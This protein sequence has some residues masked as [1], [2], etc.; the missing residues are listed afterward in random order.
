MS[1]SIT[2]NNNSSSNNNNN[3]DAVSP[4]LANNLRR[5][6]FQ[7][8]P[9][10]KLKMSD[11]DS[12]LASPDIQV[13]RKAVNRIEDSDSDAGTPVK[14]FDAKSNGD[15]NDKDE[16]LAYLINLYPNRDTDDLQEVLITVDWDLDKAKA[17][18]STTKKRKKTSSKSNKKKRR[19]GR[20]MDEEDGEPDSDEKTYKSKVFDSDDDS[21]VEVSNDLTGDKKAVFDFMQTAILAELLMMHQCSQKK[22]EAIIT[23]RP[24]ED[25]R[26]MVDKFQHNKYLD[27]ELLNSAQVLLA[28]RNVVEVLMK[29]CLRLSAN[30]EKAVAAGASMIK[31]QPKGLSPELKLT[32]YQMVGINW[33]AVL[34]SQNVNGILA[35]EMGLGKTIQVI[36]FLTYLKEANLVGENDGPHLIIVPSS[37][38]NNWINEFERWSPG[39]NIVQYYGNPDERK[40]IRMGW[41][42]GE[43]DDVDVIITTYNLTSSTPEERRLFRV[44]P[45]TYVVVD[46]AHMLKNMSTIRYENLVRINAKHRILLTGTPLQNNLLELMSLLMFV[47]PSLFAGKQNDL[48]SLFSKNPKIA[49]AAKDQPFFER[50]QVKNAKQIMRPFVLRRLKSQVLKDLPLKTDEVIKCSLTEKQ[51][52]MYK[53]LMSEFSEEAGSGVPF[54]GPG[55]MMQLRKLANHPLLHRNFYDE[56]KLR[57]MAKK[58]AKDSTYKETNPD[59]VFDDLYWM[60]D[61]AI[62]GLTRFHRCLAGYGLPQEMVLQ[63]AKLE[64]LDE[65][66]PV[67]K[68]D[69]HRVL[70]FSQFTMLLD[71][72]EEYLT[73]R[74]HKFLRLDGQT[75]VPDR[76]ALIDEFT[77][78]SSIFVFLLSTRAGGLGINLTAADTVIIHDIDFNPYN[79]KQAEDR[80]HRM[81]QKNPVRIIRLLAENTIEEGMYEIAQEKLHLEAQV[82][83]NEENE[84]TDRKSVLRLLK[85]TLGQDIHNKSLSLSPTKASNKS[86]DD[87]KVEEF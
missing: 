8:K 27:T 78:D 49:A 10:D 52:E 54:N 6:R 32:S 80:S 17:R 60:S 74:C 53:E 44:L 5:F 45:I 63:S 84:N 71:I 24:F 50:E 69:G 19:K 82:T 67:M 26:D 35:D 12:N 57:P 41:R 11:E 28:T 55:M 23:A 59:H 18:L 43:L 14:K 65:L 15:T 29:K 36:A 25:W 38:M 81:G 83:E 42:Q 77:E 87:I 73:I 51:R 21:D 56:S 1:D 2:N 4:T 7:K 62:L 16:K 68:K 79:D 9:L 48:K 37:T 31:E 75:P 64:K 3:Q 22:A 66:L 34:H 76:Q 30:M 46:E 33:L 61:Y 86:W 39:L 20:N 47:M 58:L 72:L 70:I 40:D 85:M 13:R